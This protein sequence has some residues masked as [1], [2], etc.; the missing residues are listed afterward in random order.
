MNLSAGSTAATFIGGGPSALE[1]VR[2]YVTANESDSCANPEPD[3]WTTMNTTQMAICAS[4]G[5]LGFVPTAN[6]LDIHVNLTIPY[7]SLR[8]GTNQENTITAT[9]TTI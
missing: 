6:S 2:F 3:V 8:V 4:T 9:G 1:A 5:G 7:D